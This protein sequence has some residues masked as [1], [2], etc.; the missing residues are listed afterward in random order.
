MTS[1]KP[2]S[3]SRPY[4]HFVNSNFHEFGEEGTGQSITTTINNNKH[5]NSEKWEEWNYVIMHFGF[6]MND[7]AVVTLIMP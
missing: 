2:T 7:S 5:V 3:L 4:F 6:Q 1:S